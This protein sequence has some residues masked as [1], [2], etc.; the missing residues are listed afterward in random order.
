MPF[1][2]PVAAV[3]NFLVRLSLRKPKRSHPQEEDLLID[4]PSREAVP[5]LNEINDKLQSSRTR[6]PLANTG[7]DWTLHAFHAWVAEKNLRDG[8]GWLRMGLFQRRTGQMKLP[9]KTFLVRIH[10]ALFKNCLSPQ[11]L[12][13]L[14]NTH[15][16]CAMGLSANGWRIL[17]IFPKPPDFPDGTESLSESEEGL[18][19]QEPR[20]L[21]ENAPQILL[22]DEQ[23]D[24]DEDDDP[25]AL[26]LEQMDCGEDEQQDGGE[27]DDPAALPLEQMDCGEDEQ[28]DGDEDDDPAALPLEQM[29]CGEDTKG[30]GTLYLGTR[31]RRLVQVPRH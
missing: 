28:Q 23:Q 31:S 14:L 29:D 16:R 21:F 4:Y 3:T 19:L 25:A 12:Y 26:P 8:D 7:R 10:A 2:S 30:I 17:D 1:L 11:E 15:M 22:E 24:G 20:N 6:S 5:L 27:D 9:E 13:K 18:D